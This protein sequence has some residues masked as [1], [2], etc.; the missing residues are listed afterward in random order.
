[1]TCEGD[2]TVK[3]RH[4]RGRH[5]KNKGNGKSLSQSAKASKTSI[6]LVLLQVK[7]THPDPGVI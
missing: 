1:M 3:A 5:K 6:C 2:G 7:F 4:Q